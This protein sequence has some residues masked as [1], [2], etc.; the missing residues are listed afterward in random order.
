VQ[1]HP[2]ELGRVELRLGFQ[3]DT[4]SVQM[5]VERKETYD[6]FLQGRTALERDLAQV[7]INL[8]GGGLDLR[9][10]QPERHAP[11]VAPRLTSASLPAEGVA[12]SA[13]VGSVRLG[14]GLLDILA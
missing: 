2:A 11:A 9:F 10:S 7:G 13:P 5:T 14:G 4:L 3:G 6:S 1:L 8:G 12:A